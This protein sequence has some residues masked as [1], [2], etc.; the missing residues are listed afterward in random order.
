MSPVFFY[1]INS[2]NILRTEIMVEYILRLVL[3]NEQVITLNLKKQ[4]VLWYRCQHLSQ[5]VSSERRLVSTF[6]RACFHFL[7]KQD[8]GLRS[9]HSRRRQRINTTKEKNRTWQK[10]AHA[11]GFGLAIGMALAASIIH[12]IK[13]L[14]G[15]FAGRTLRI[16]QLSFSNPTVFVK[17]SNWLPHAFF[18][19]L[20]FL[21]CNECIPLTRILNKNSSFF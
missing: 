9:P 18:L 20:S 4:F 8:V 2:Q 3:K 12:S 10:H 21:F 14:F 6:S 16:N 13:L 1:K 11:S 17:F 7:V 15:S 19:A 5:N